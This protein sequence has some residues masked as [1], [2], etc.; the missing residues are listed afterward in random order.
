M[1]HSSSGRF[2][3]EIKPNQQVKFARYAGWDFRFATAPYPKR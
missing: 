3:K 2:M 1:R